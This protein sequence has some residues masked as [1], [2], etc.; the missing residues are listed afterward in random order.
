MYVYIYIYIY[1]YTHIAYYII[2]YIG[3]P[4]QGFSAIYLQDESRDSI[5]KIHIYIYI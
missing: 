3:K 5:T 2:L 1:V 4:I